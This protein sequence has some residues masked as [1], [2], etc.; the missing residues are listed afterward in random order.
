MQW[1]TTGTRRRRTSSIN[2]EDEYASLRSNERA[3]T[4]VKVA[5]AKRIASKDSAL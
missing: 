1:W 4:R 5:R 3:A 2:R